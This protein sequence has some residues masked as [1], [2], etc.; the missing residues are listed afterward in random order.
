LSCAKQG[1]PPGGP[2]DLR[3]PIVL[4]TYPTPDS[5]GVSRDIKPTFQFD[6]WVDRASV[7]AA[8]FISPFPE[9][10]MRFKWRGKKLRLEFPEPLR[11][12]VT[13][14]ITLGTGIKDMRGNSLA[15]A[16]T[17]AFATGDHLDRAAISGRIFEDAD[18][19]G[20]QVWAYD[21][22]LTPQPDPREI[23]P[24]YVTQ[25]EE[26]G[27]FELTHLKEGSYRI[28]AINDRRRN[29]RW[30]PNE[31]RIGIAYMD[32]ETVQD[33]TVYGANLKMTLLDTIGARLT[34]VRVTDQNH[35]LLRFSEVVTP[36]TSPPEISIRDTANATLGVI[37]A[38]PSPSD[39]L[40]WRIVTD[41]QQAGDRY[42]LWVE[43]FLDNNDNPNLLDTLVFEGSNVPDTIGA[44]LT[45]FLPKDK[46][47]DIPDKPHIRATFD[48][49]IA[50]DSLPLSLRNEQGKLLPIDWQIEG[51]IFEAVPKDSL[52]G[53]SISAA[54]NLRLITDLFGNHDGDS[55]VYWEFSILPRD[56]LGE[57]Q[58][59]ISDLDSSGIGPVIIDAR[60]L[61]QA[62]SPWHGRW[63]IGSPGKYSLQWLL[64]GKYRIQVFRDENHNGKYDYGMPYP[65][66]YAERFAVYPD[67]ITVRSRWETAGVDLNLPIRQA[68][69]YH[70]ET[71]DTS[72][73]NQ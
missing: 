13:H 32:V 65:F 15:S 40:T 56:T 70:I 20:T 58:G 33:F 17:L 1:I 66:Q 49:E 55:T 5:T 4:S 64:P 38:D 37:M 10:T 48:K 51:A 45:D 34:S 8:T 73:A 27:E 29:R 25:A 47:K 14:V 71:E 9:G 24:D 12:N 44:R 52:P 28:F 19:T 53:A 22:S 46:A 31:D 61:D 11:E 68:L 3:G 7:V 57:I 59:V 50:A 35:L 60:R 69:I 6:E 18:L 63:Q 23:G 62:S 21:L 30:D 67:T 2:E 39:S 16:Y 72:K 41:P 36:S 42:S 43:G 54:L 26:S